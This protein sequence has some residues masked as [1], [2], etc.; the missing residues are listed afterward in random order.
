MKMILFTKIFVQLLLLQ[1]EQIFCYLI[2][3]RI[4]IQ[5]VKIY[6]S[7]KQA[8]NYNLIM[9]QLKRQNVIVLA[10]E[11]SEL[12]VLNVE[13]FFSKKAIEDNFYNT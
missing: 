3:K 8:V 12:N 9:L 13:N 5:K 1:M 4:F 7:S 6:L 2:G 11:S 10:Q